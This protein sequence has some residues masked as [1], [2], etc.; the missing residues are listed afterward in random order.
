MSPHSH[1]GCLLKKIAMFVLWSAV[2]MTFAQTT[3]AQNVTQAPASLTFG[4]PTGTIPTGTPPTPVSAVQTVRLNI[5]LAAGVNLSFSNPSATITP[6]PSAFT[7]TGNSCTGQY[8]GPF[9]GTCQVTVVFSSSSTTLQTASLQ[10]SGGGFELPAIPLSGAFGAIKLWDATSVQHSLNGPVFTL[11]YNAIAAANLSLSCP[12]GASAILSGTPGYFFPAGS[13]VGVLGNVLVDNYITLAINQTPVPTY[14]QVYVP[15]NLPPLLQINV[16]EAVYSNPNSNLSPAFPPGNVCQ[17]T[18]A[19]SDSDGTNFYPECFSAAYR[20][21]V[22]NLVGEN[23]DSIANTNN[24]LPDQGDGT[25][26]GVAPLNISAFFPSGPSVQASLKALDYGGYFETSTVFLVTNCSPTGIAS[27]G[28]ITGVPITTAN[29]ASQTQTFTFDSAPNQNIAFTSSDA[30]SIQSGTTTPAGV[31][32]IV[33]DI[34]ISQTA[35]SQLVAGT[36]A[37]PVVCYRLTGEDDLC[38]GF[39]IQCFDPVTKTTSGS[40]C[41]TPT[42][43]AIMMRNLYD[44]AQFASPDAPVNGT[45][46]LYNGG[47]TDACT[48]FTNAQQNVENGSCAPTSLFGAQPTLMGAAFLLGS[49]SWLSG[50]GCSLTGILKGDSCPLN[51]STGLYGAADNGPGGGTPGRNSVYVAGANA[52]LPFSTGVSVTGPGA[53]PAANPNPWVNSEDVTANFTANSATY[54][55]GANNPSPNGFITSPVYSWTFGTTKAFDANGNPI[56]LPDPTYPVPGDTTIWNNG[57]SQNFVAPLCPPSTTTTFTSTSA[58]NSPLATTLEG[59]Y[60]LHYFTTACDLSEEL[61]YNPSPAQLVDPTANWAS[62]RYLQ[63]GVDITSPTLMCS[64]AGTAGNNG[65]YRSDVTETC[66]ATDQNFVP[67]VTGS[68][69]LPLTLGIQGTK[70]YNPAPVS[71]NVGANNANAAV[72][73]PIQKVSDLAGNPSTTSYTTPLSIDEALPTITGTFSVPGNSFVIGSNVS[74][75][76]A[77]KDVGS[78]LANCENQ[79]PAACPPAPA[80][81][82]LSYS[83]AQPINTSPAAF[84]PHVV[85]LVAVDCAGNG[86]NGNVQ[87]TITASPADVAIHEGASSD[88]VKPGDKLTYKVWVYDLT[89]QTNAYGVVVNALVPTNV[90]A[91]GAVISAVVTDVSCTWSA[92]SLTVSCTG[93][94]GGTPCTVNGGSIQCPVGTLPPVYSLKG[95]MVTITVPISSALKLG[96]TFPVSAAVTSD[97]DPNPKNNATSDTVII[98]TYDN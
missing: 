26:G 92:A 27:G 43:N 11:N 12:S 55:G 89:P 24:L 83:F 8:T 38:K 65:W 21:A 96:Y 98:G 73:P 23:A 59:I 16:Y 32:P 30:V 74:I 82:A 81:G 34:A 97:N 52:A 95:A 60:N 42:V 33:T 18:D 3:K 39:L 69:F 35:F 61:L 70:T 41:D 58:G 64:F 50:A 91:P 72:P 45:N 67:G 22:T 54:Y 63:F 88:H 79:A 84:G 10:I 25:A 94:S 46:F 77:C 37:A 53:P 40:N 17:N 78:G 87:Y 47:L 51:T 75:T 68:G 56:P 62:F 14:A 19:T 93:A 85:P 44:S 2:L 13:E 5:S 20:A 90:I 86:T 36:S 29:T 71:T 6:T 57:V 9:T 31:T 15:A 1:A 28:S 49:D 80:S 48:V 4:I 66:S 76:Y 7:I